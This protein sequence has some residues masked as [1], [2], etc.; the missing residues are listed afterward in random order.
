MRLLTACMFALVFIIPAVSFSKSAGGDKHRSDQEL[1]TIIRKKAPFWLVDGD[2]NVRLNKD[3][4]FASDAAGGALNI[5]GKWRV[6]KGELKLLWNIDKKE[7]V[8][9]VTIVNRAPLI[10]G[11]SLKDG[12]YTLGSGG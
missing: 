11:A 10:G 4:T 12:K 3:A 1:R 8:Y 6:E 5:E 9:P 7:K 2:I